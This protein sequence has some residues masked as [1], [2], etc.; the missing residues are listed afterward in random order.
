MKKYAKSRTVKSKHALLH[1]EIG[2]KISYFRAINNMTHS[3]V[4]DRLNMPLGSYHSLE[5]G[6]R[7]IFLAEA[8]QLSQIF[9]VSLLEFTHFNLNDQKLTIPPTP[10]NLLYTKPARET[11]VVIDEK[12]IEKKVFQVL[13]RFIKS[14]YDDFCEKN[15]M[16]R[17]YT[18]R[19]VH[20]TKPTTDEETTE[21]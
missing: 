5:K 8:I 3:E 18:K 4:A 19:A 6:T 10:S 21:N 14:E 1:K 12:I 9:S 15:N 13:S 16:K 2:R 7:S 17:K 11:K 20:L